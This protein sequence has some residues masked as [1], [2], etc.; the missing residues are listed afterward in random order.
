MT[1]SFPLS[2]CRVVSLTTELGRNF[3]FG[4]V[5]LIF[6]NVQVLL[7]SFFSHNL[8]WHLA[9]WQV[10]ARSRA[11]RRRKLT[12]HQ[13]P[14]IRNHPPCSLILHDGNFKDKRAVWGDPFSPLSAI[15]SCGGA[16]YAPLPATAHADDPDV[17]PF[18]HLVAR[19]QGMRCRN[20]RVAWFDLTSPR[21]SR[22]ENGFRPD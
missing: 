12:A 10:T 1:A 2:A 3:R 8:N 11:A 15:C 21:P 14:F 5:A 4:V 19:V 7:C 6:R 9:S 18:N 22:K 20:P 16:R 13:V 17:P